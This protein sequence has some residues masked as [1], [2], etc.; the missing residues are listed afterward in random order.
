MT[1]FNERSNRRVGQIVAL[2]FVGW[3]IIWIFR[4][5]TGAVH[6]EIMEVVGP[7]SSVRMGLISSCYFM[8]Y[9]AMQI[10]GGFLMDRFG[11]QRILIPSFALMALGFALVGFA[12]SIE[13]IYMGS[14]L[15]GVGSGTY[16]SGAF[17]LS[18]ENVPR[19]SKYFAT[20]I[21]NSGGA[22]GMLMGYLYASILV[23][24]LNVD[25]RAMIFFITVL[26]IAMIPMI[27]LI[28]RDDG[29][30]PNTSVRKTQ[31]KKVTSWELMAGLFSPRLIS[32]YFFYF[33]T[34]YGYY[35]IVSWLP[36][37][38]QNERGL[39]GVLAGYASSVIA[40][41][42]I[43]GALFLGKIMDKFSRR[44]VQFLTGIQI[45]SGL[46]LVCVTVF[47]P[48]GLILLTLALYGVMGKQAVDPLIVPCVTDQFGD[49][50]LSTGL[51]VFNFFGMSASVIGPLV[52]G[53]LQDTQ[54]S[55]IVGF[56]IAGALLVAS[57]LIFRIVHRNDK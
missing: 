1:D 32:S 41:V 29:K 9:V 20:A 17:S 52:N 54:G 24:Q 18:T 49:I 55:Q 13:M 31:R 46:L 44:R 8:G 30:K 45:L 19:E 39:S 50:A 7:Q 25:W 43:P 15:A 57:S 12:C 23:K 3:F 10:P 53:L 37:F 34:C 35:M 27:R 42:S 26:A 14:V 40:L 16:Y 21:V 36:S 22:F 56:Y 5:L 4:T 6:P 2:L 48:V 33:C 38:L 11:K 47:R 51:G 28:L